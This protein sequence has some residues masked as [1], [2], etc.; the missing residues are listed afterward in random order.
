MKFKREDLEDLKS[1]WEPNPKG[2][3]LL[4]NEFVDLAEGCVA[5]YNLV[6]AYNEIIYGVQYPIGCRSSNNLDNLDEEVECYEC[7]PFTKV[8]IQYRSVKVKSKVIPF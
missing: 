2:F 5:W 8:S 4:Q 1:V 3:N 7:E 6:F